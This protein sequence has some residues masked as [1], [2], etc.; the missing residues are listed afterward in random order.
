MRRPFATLAVALLTGAA[1]ACGADDAQD[2]LTLRTP[3]GPREEPAKRTGDRGAERPAAD[4]R[5]PA[6]QARAV[7]RAW[8]DALRRDRPRR[9]ARYFSVP[10]IIADSGEATL[11]TRAEVE[12]FQDAFPCGA[13][14]LHVERDGRYFVGTFDLTRRPGHECRALRHLLRVAFVLRERKIAEWREIPQPVAPSDPQDAQP[15]LSPAPAP[16]GSA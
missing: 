2:R 15:E 1:A 6:G 12:R 11:D 14:L 7:L 10:A 4:A 8:G 13:R 9:A 5:V 16:P 3:P